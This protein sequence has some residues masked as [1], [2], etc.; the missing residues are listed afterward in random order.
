MVRPL[1]VPAAKPFRRTVEAPGAPSAETVGSD[2]D[3]AGEEEEEEEEAGAAGEG[4]I[5]QE[6]GVDLWRKE[7]EPGVG[8]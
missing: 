7:E 3:G 6:R 5:W 8:S 2:L 1:A 4:A